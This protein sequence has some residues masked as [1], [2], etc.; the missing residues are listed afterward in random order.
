M[1][2]TYKSTHTVALIFSAHTHIHRATDQ[3]I[4]SHCRTG[5]PLQSRRRGSPGSRCPRTSWSDAAN[6]SHT[7]CCRDSSGSSCPSYLHLEQEQS[8][9][10]E[11]KG[12]WKQVWEGTWGEKSNGGCWWIAKLGYNSKAA[13]SKHFVFFIDVPKLSQYEPTLGAGWLKQWCFGPAG[14]IGIGLQAKHK[15][16]VCW[17]QI[18]EDHIDAF[19]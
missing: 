13:V 9:V 7:S 3:D 16:L 11:D 2:N 4:S 12:A 19:K 6:P 10:A 18:R 1:N 15:S 17:T 5:P 14:C 8:T